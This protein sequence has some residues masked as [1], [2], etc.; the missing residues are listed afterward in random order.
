LKGV[1]IS[2]SKVLGGAA[3]ANRTLGS[4]SI[5]D[6]L[7]AGVSSRFSPTTR[8]AFVVFDNTHVSQSEGYRFALDV[9][10]GVVRDC[11]ERELP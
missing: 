6:L 3:D 8:D 11:L 2:P 5:A 9:I 1:I 7:K 10:G 4:Q